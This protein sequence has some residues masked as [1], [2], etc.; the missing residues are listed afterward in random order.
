M[1]YLYPVSI[2]S[3]TGHNLSFMFA[4]LQKRHVSINNRFLHWLI[5][6]SEFGFPTSFKRHSFRQ[7]SWTVDRD[8]ETG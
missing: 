3:V 2:T 6:M 4:D 7:I 8:W 1:N 5:G